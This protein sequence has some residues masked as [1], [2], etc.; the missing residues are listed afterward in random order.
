[1]LFH[2]LVVVFSVLDA[3]NNGVGITPAMGFNTWN[4]FS[5]GLNEDYV[6]AAAQQIISRK[7][8]DIGYIYINVCSFV[9][10]FHM[11]LQSWMIVGKCLEIQTMLLLLGPI[12]Q[13]GFMHFRNICMIW[14]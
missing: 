8:K 9:F 5:C 4:K 7:L 11:F 13:A 14:D 2:I 1:M 10:F 12:F 3:R 6:K